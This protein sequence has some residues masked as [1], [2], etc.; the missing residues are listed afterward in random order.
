MGNIVTIEANKL[1]TSSVTGAAYVPASGV[2]NLALITDTPPDPT[3]TTAGV[4]VTNTGGSTYARQPLTGGW[5]TA[6]G[7]TITNTGVFSFTGMPACTIKSI[8]LWD[9]AGTPIRRWFGALTLPKVVNAGD[10]VTFA[11]SSISITL[12]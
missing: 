7:G 11:A 4:E 5:G 3:A 8:E 2:V 10:T 6:S 1:L 12:S 9:S